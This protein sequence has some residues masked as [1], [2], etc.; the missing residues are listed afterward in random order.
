MQALSL[1]CLSGKLT[2]IM[3]GFACGVN[4]IKLKEYTELTVA[5]LR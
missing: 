2:F 3:K 1:L 4:A 5:Y